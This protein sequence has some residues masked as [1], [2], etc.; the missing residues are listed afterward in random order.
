MGDSGSLSLGFILGF[1]AVK[2]CM[3]TPR[4]VYNPH[5]IVWAWSFLAVPCFD[6]VRIFFFRIMHG[7]SP[8]QPDKKHIHHKLMACGLSQHKALV[9]IV[10]LQLVIIAI[11]YLLVDATTKTFIF[12][13]DVALYAMVNLAANFV[14]RQREAMAGNK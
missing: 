10:A 1:L 11:S 3:D 8:F 7:R 4:A 13:V 9:A 6:V 5:R 2:L 12:I 14:I